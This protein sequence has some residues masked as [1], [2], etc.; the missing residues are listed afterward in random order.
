[1]LEGLLDLIQSLGIQAVIEVL[2]DTVFKLLELLA[3][4]VK[5][6]LHLDNRLGLLGYLLLNV[7]QNVWRPAVRCSSRS[8]KL[9]LQRVLPGWL[10]CQRLNWVKNTV[11]KA[12]RGLRE[13]GVL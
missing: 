2:V 7:S 1:L 13:L 3:H 11:A 5:V 8:K 9:T 12:L 6:R 4:L 10:S